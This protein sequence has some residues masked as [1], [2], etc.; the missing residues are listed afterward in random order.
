[1]LYIENTISFLRFDYVVRN[2]IV[3]R[4]L[5]YVNFV[6]GNY[7]FNVLEFTEILIPKVIFKKKTAK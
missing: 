5:F 4:R 2:N 3:N 6:F 1:M 7:Y